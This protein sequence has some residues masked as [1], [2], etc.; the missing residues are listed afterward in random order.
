M[1]TVLPDVVRGREFRNVVD[2]AKN[3]ECYIGGFCKVCANIYAP[4]ELLVKCVVNIFPH[5]TST[6]GI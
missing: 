2:S 5:V 3:G 4:T 1:Y 6:R